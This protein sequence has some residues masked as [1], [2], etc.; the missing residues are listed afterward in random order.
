MDIEIATH[1]CKST[2]NYFHLSWLQLNKL[3]C[4]LERPAAEAETNTSRDV[5]NLTRHF[6]LLLHR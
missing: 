6:I 3:R 1:L 4:K 5:S 2:Q